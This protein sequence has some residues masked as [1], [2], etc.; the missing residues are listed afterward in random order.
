MRDSSPPPPHDIVI[1]LG[2]P[3]FLMP[4]SPLPFQVCQADRKA[5]RYRNAD[6]YGPGP[7]RARFGGGSG[8][9]FLRDRAAE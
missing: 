3:S 8:P 6:D 1:P 5:V 7:P 9:L 4:V 2:N